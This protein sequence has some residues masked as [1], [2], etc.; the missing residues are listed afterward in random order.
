MAR[1][2]YDIILAPTD[3]VCKGLLVPA[4]TAEVNRD[5]L[6]IRSY[7]LVVLLSTQNMKKELESMRLC[8]VLVKP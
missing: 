5:D 3:L 2:V 1:D 7:C 4:H 8:I 6:N